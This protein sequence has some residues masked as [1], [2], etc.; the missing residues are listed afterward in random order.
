MSIS[1]PEENS[2]SAIRFWRSQNA[3][4][5]VSSKPEVGRA[6]VS[7]QNILQAVL[8]A[9]ITARQSV[10]CVCKKLVEAGPFSGYKYRDLLASVGLIVRLEDDEPKLFLLSAYSFKTAFPGL[11]HAVP[12]LQAHKGILVGT[13]SK[14]VAPI[15]MAVVKPSRQMSVS[16]AKVPAM[17][18]YSYP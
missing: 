13:I 2:A 7:E 17:P 1:Y 11:E 16:R 4:T 10:E 8:T 18:P 5:L 15:R 3:L 12:W 6:E 9:K 14:P